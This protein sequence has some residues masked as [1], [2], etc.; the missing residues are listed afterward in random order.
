MQ[1]PGR[2]SCDVGRIRI[3]FALRVLGVVVCRVT[4]PSICRE[5]CEGS[6]VPFTIVARAFGAVTL[7][8]S[9]LVSGARTPHGIANAFTERVS[10]RK[11]EVSCHGG[12]IIDLVPRGVRYHYW[13]LLRVLAISSVVFV[14]VK[15]RRM[16]DL[17]SLRIW[18]ALFSDMRISLACDCVAFVYPWTFGPW[19][20]FLAWPLKWAKSKR[21]NTGL[22]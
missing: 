18:C 2:Q 13:L 14:V 4:T 7:L 17:C 11:T 21:Q 6:R 9:T 3:L 19:H 15:E 20:S 8:T 10:G 22:F 1:P 5:A 12:N 16:I